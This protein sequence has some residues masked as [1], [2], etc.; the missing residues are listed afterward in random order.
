[1]TWEMP[2]AWQSVNTHWL[3]VNRQLILKS[4][5]VVGCE[6]FYLPAETHTGYYYD[7]TLPPP[8]KSCADE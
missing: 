6:R 8:M 2:P 1:M 5:R 4:Y 3:S 7:S